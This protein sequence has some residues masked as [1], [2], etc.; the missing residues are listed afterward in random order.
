MGIRSP[1]KEAGISR[2][3]WYQQ[4]AEAKAGEPDRESEARP[5]PSLP[6]LRFMEASN[7]P[8]L[9]DDPGYRR[10]SRSRRSEVSR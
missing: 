9:Y 3:L 1:W 10:P 6:R 4:R 8:A 2:S 7:D 5:K